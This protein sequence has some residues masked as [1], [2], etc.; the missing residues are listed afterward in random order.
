M[1]TIEVLRIDP[2]PDAPHTILFN[3]ETSTVTLSSTWVILRHLRKLPNGEAF[4]PTLPDQRPALV[5]VLLL[6]A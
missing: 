2:D 4:T 5:S 3:L 6:L 1:N